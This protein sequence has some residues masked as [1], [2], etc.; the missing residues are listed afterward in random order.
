M[1][2]EP[3]SNTSSSCPPTR[4][5]Y[6]RGRPVSLTRSRAIAWRA[7]LL[8]GAA[9]LVIGGQALAESADGAAGT[10][11][12]AAAAAATAAADEAAIGL[13]EVVVTAQK[14]ATN[15]QETPISLAVM[16]GEELARRHIQSLSD[17][18]DGAIPSL[19]IEP[20]FSRSS[21]LI[22]RLGKEAMARQ[23]DM[24][25]DDALDY[26]RSQLTLALSTEDVVEGVSAFFEK[27]EPVWKNR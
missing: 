7:G 9:A 18:R 21:A 1:M 4:F 19:R 25:L 11:T 17:L 23:A 15:L 13:Q 27:R 16:G 6:S 20:M 24:D 8:A 14:R 26:L 22:M 12:M 3:P 2:N 10:A 5:T